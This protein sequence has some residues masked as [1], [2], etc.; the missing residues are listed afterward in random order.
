MRY[1][2]SISS[3]LDVYKKL[4]RRLFCSVVWCGMVWYGVVWG[5]L[6]GVVR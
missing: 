3:S 1:A 5:V 2:H 6:Y 4:K